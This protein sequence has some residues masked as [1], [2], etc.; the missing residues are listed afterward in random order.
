MTIPFETLLQKW[1]QDPKFRAEYERVGPEMELA[2]N[3]AEARRDAEL[4]QAQLA[5]RMKT[6][7]SA[8]ARLESGRMA[9]KWGTLQRYAQAVG[10][11]VVVHLETIGAQARPS[12]RELVVSSPAPSAKKAAAKGLSK[13]AAPKGLSKKAAALKPKA[14]KRQGKRA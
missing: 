11:R 1:M 10:K 2:M 8:I 7:Q 9:P 4:S 14:A 6:T 5:K 3:L 13:K 12:L